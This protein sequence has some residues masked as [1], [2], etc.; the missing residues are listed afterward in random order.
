MTDSHG[1]VP[2]EKMLNPTRL[3]EMLDISERHLT[4]LRREDKTFPAPRMLG[5]LPRWSPT[6]I[7]QWVEAAASLAPLMPTADAVEPPTR[8]RPAKGKGKR[9]GVQRV[10]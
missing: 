8:A 4:D 1:F 6:T 9:K 5:A 2:T 7:R 10:F 3:A